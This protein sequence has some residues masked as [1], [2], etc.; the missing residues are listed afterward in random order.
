[1]AASKN[2]PEGFIS[3]RFE[4]VCDRNRAASAGFRP[5]G[6]DG[7]IHIKGRACSYRLAPGHFKDP[8]DVAPAIA[9]RGHKNLPA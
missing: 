6:G 9:A 7:V 4:I 8:H 1:M 3:P 2:K 5:Q